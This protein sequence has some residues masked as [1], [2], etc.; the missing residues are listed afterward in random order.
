M[1]VVNILGEGIAK[2]NVTLTGLCVIIIC[3]SDHTI[4]IHS[5]KNG[6]KLLSWHRNAIRRSGCV[7]SLVFLKTNHECSEG[8]GLLWIKPTISQTLALGQ[9]LQK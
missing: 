8:A 6:K 9:C 2:N 1:W 7:E 5:F 3:S 4:N